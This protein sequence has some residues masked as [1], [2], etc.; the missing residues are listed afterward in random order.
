[1]VYLGAVGRSGL[2]SFLKCQIE[3]SAKHGLLVAKKAHSTP[4]NTGVL[5]LAEKQ[6]GYFT[7]CFCICLVRGPDLC[8]YPAPVWAA[9]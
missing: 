1:M 7:R 6:T 4:D 9:T 5:S 3:K 8:S 2:A